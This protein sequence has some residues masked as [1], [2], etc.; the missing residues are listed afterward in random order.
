MLEK[1]A[2]VDYTIHPLLRGRWSPRAFDPAP[3]PREQVLSLLEAARWSPSSNNGQPW[4]FV[5]IPRTDQDAFD[6]AV[7]SLNESN[8]VWAQHAPL[9]ILAVA[10]L[11]RDNGA[12]NRTAL[13]DLGQAVAHLS[14][15]AAASGLW[16]HQMG[17]FSQDRARELFAVPEGYEPVTFIAIGRQG[18]PVLLP[19]NLR[20]REQAP[21]TRKPL[22]A[23]AFGGEWGQ[24]SPLLAE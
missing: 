11:N 20:E 5:V 1:P 2:T 17:G 12:P 18:D 6:R 16:V 19:E 22:D 21:R 8:V 13:Y 24:P 7:S 14:V 3:L 4:S 15:Q 23:F 10:R 9:L